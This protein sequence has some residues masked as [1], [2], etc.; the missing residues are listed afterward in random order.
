MK[1]RAPVKEDT[2]IRTGDIRRCAVNGGGEVESFFAVVISVMS[3]SVTVR[4]FHKDDWGAARYLI[5][6]IAPTGLEYAMFVDGKDLRLPVAC[7]GRKSGRISKTDMRN[8]RK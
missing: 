3:G 1:F 2:E 6:D 4:R 7:I 5:K 8:L